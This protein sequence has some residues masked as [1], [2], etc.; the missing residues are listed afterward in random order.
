MK[1]SIV[2]ERKEEALTAVSRLQAKKS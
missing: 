2:S 1:I